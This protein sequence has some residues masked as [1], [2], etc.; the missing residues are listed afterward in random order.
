MY[1]LTAEADSDLT[2]IYFY[3]LEEFGEQ[4][5]DAYAYSLKTACQSLADFPKL[6][7]LCPEIMDGLRRHEHLH[8]A[9]YYQ[10]DDRDIIII[11]ILHQQMDA[12]RHITST[13]T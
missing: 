13:D 7:R 3:S 5:A 10:E 1:K 6:G 4:R 9:I 12:T 8:H 11:R 2:A